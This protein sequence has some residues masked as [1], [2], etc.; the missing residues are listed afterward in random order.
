MPVDPAERLQFAAG[1]GA[2]VVLTG[3]WY[4]L[5]IF[6]L[7]LYLKGGAPNVMLG[8]AIAALVGFG[9]TGWLS[10]FKL[11]IDGTSLEYRDGFYKMTKFEVCDIVCVRM[12]RVFWPLFG[13]RLSVPRLE[14]RSKTDDIILINTKPFRRND[15]QQ[16]RRK[17]NEILP[18]KVFKGLET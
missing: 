14:I 17:I 15:F 13:P 5:A 12:V 6:Y 8:G 16:F 4:L 11:V 7:M 2:Y 18:A 9:M 3:I 10:G 1:I